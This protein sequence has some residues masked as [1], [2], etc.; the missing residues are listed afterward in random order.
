MSGRLFFRLKVSLYQ[1][2]YAFKLSSPRF[3]L[4]TAVKSSKDEA[5]NGRLAS[6]NLEKAVR[7]LH[8]GG[9]VVIEDAIPHGD[10]NHL[11][12]KV[13][14]DAQTLQ[15]RSKYMSSGVE[16]RSTFSAARHLR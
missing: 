6:R 13:V 5:S 7:C 14:Q 8:E 4:Y 15:S 12:A 11:D 16:R 1:S 10:L 9:L 3:Y 2:G